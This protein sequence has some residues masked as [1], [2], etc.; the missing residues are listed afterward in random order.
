MVSRTHVCVQGDTPTG[1]S[2]WSSDEFLQFTSPQEGRA[3]PGS[4]L[5]GPS[6][7]P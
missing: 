4:S 6:E 7:T 2:G 3:V 5:R 1:A